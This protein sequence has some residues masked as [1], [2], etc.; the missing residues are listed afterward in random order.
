MPRLS[1]FRDLA[2]LRRV[3][4]LGRSGSGKTTLAVRIGARLGLPVVHLDRLYW[5][6]DWQEPDTE[7]F[8]AR[9][10]AAVAGDAWVSEGNYRET[11]PLRLPRADA[12]V[13]LDRSRWLCL[14]RVLWRTYVRPGRRPDLPPGCPEQV[15]WRLIKLIWS[16][17][18]RVWPRIDAARLADGPDIPLIR[19]HNALEVAAFL[20]SLP[21]A[22]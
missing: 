20:K 16:F 21:A 9:V 18:R 10:A 12:V 5:Q 17:D 2:V 11:F 15:D 14:W 22:R 8:L 6:P 3:V 4:V 13:V 1:A 19:L 7:S